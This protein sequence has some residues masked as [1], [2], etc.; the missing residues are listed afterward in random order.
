MLSRRELLVNPLTESASIQK[1]AVQVVYVHR[2]IG[3]GHDPIP[4]RPLLG[5]VKVTVGK[6]L[7]VVN[8]LVV[9]E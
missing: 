2:T 1:E 3:A 7:V 9:F 4:E 5:H 6:Q 8:C